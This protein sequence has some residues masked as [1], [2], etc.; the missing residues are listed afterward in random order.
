MVANIS[1]PAN[2]PNE[3]ISSP[4]S[5]SPPIPISIT[6]AAV[7]PPMPISMPPAGAAPSGSPILDAGPAIIFAASFKEPS[8]LSIAP[9]V[10]A[11]NSAKKSP[12]TPSKAD[13][14]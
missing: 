2:V 3:P 9:E 1:M 14:N 10:I 6:P 12:S 7:S 5:I 4:S 13:P 8:K 11:S